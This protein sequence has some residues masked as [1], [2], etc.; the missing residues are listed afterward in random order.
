MKAVLMTEAGPADVLQLADV[1]EPQITS[2]TQIKV[3]LKAAGV[4]PVDT[5]IRSR[6][7]FVA[8]GYPA[9]LGCDGAGVVVETGDRVTRFMPGDDV[10]FCHGGLGGAQGNYAEFTVLDEKE[11]EMKP[12]LLS[13]QEAAALPLVAITAWEALFDR[14][15][16]KSR[17]TVLIHGG[18]GGVGHVAIQLARS[19]GARVATTVSS[20]EKADFV[21]RLGADKIINYRDSDFVEEV[22]AWTR[23]A[24]VD[25]VLESIN[26]EVFQR[27]LSA[28]K[29]Y[30]HVN[31]LLDPGTD[32]SW[33]EAR[34]RNLSISFTLMLTPMLM[35]LAEARRR[36]G[37]ILHRCAKLVTDFKLKPAVTDVLP[38]KDAA[39]AHRMIETGHTRGKIV[40]A[41]T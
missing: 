21:K 24:G 4:N 10:W 35:N 19:A 40:L 1:D 2:P 3:Q 6:G 16:L 5:K 37:K 31:T 8:D 34:N 23:G 27:S 9:I 7:L 32:I 20:A 36:Q 26:P 29:V 22:M 39:V 18:A 28:A 14:A 17:Q 15:G 38:L 41:I 12:R 25:V 33:K 30:G 13:Y 11:A